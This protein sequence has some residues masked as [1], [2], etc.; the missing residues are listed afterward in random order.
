MSV[1]YYYVWKN[2]AKRVVMYRRL[3]KVMVRGAMNSCLVQFLDNEE[4]EVV[5]RN[6]LRRYAGT[7]LYFM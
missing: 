2:N 5:S 4:R 6:A 3:C 1:V 7:N